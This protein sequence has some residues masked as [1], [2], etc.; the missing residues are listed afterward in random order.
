MPS[1]PRPGFIIP[2][3]V[4][5]AA[6]YGDQAEPDAGDFQILG[7]HRNG[8]LS[9]CEFS[10]S[11]GTF[12]VT[13]G[14]NWVVVAGKAYQ[15]ATSATVTVATTGGPKF[16]LIAHTG[17]GLT[18]I[19]GDPA[20]A[21]NAVFPTLTGDVAVIAAIYVPATG[22]ATA[23]DKRLM[24]SHTLNGWNT[25]TNDNDLL[26][27][28]S[29][30]GRVVSIDSD[31]KLYWGD[32]KYASII[33][34]GN[35]LEL[36]DSVLVE[37]SLTVDGSVQGYDADFESTVTGSNLQRGTGAPGAGDPG[38]IY[39]R[40][41][42]DNS[43]FYFHTGSGWSQ[44]IPATPPTG[45]IIA[46]IASPDTSAGMNLIA[47]GWLAF[48]T[49][50]TN[51]NTEHPSLWAM[52]PAA[53]K[54][55]TSLI[56]PSLSGRTL[57][58]GTSG[59]VGGTNSV[60]IEVQNLPSHKHFSGTLSTS[61]VPNHAHAG[62]KVNAVAGHRH[63]GID[64][65]TGGGFVFTDLNGT[66]KIF[67]NIAGALTLATVSWGQVGINGKTDVQGAHTHTMN[68]T[69]DG[70]HSHTLPSDQSVGGN[71]PLSIQTP[72]MGVNYYIK[73]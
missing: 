56:L 53:W 38:D 17:N 9:G 44:F 66:G 37:G 68:V 8:V 11:G 72:F 43:A 15:I 51:A 30:D 32:D 48:G 47:E 13:S 27:L 3:Y 67:A 73:S 60:A 41:D 26:A 16:Y 23:V 34:N 31:G 4:S 45:T 65:Y 61:S 62:S 6:G 22:A 12:T 39:Q 57:T 5:L 19:E 69:P 21:E 24:L 18:A 52:A 50:V 2:N 14:N 20:V 40:A 64:G 49:T 33:A 71:L 42:G 28:R 46:H 10:F 63:L 58:G 35:T 1:T 55:G 29:P 36:S 54:S 25:G 59:E 70:G 7:N